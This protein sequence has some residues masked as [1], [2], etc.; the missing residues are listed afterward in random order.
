M[1]SLPTISYGLAISSYLSHNAFLFLI[2]VAVFFVFKLA[3]LDG[4]LRER[5]PQFAGKLPGKKIGGNLKAEFVEERRIALEKYLC[6][7][8]KKKPKKKL[9][10]SFKTIQKDEK[11]IIKKVP[12]NRALM[13]ARR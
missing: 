3:E 1:A 10:K 6:V 13:C 5:F 12:E 11:E 9:K 4:K 8:V 2:F 7:S